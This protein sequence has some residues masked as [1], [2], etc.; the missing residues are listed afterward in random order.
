MTA[1]R[2]DPAGVNA[3]HPIADVVAR[4]GVALRPAGRSHVGR[5]PFHRDRGRPNFYVYPATGRFVC[6][7]C[8]AH[9][10]A[11]DF[12]AAREGCRFR[13]AVAL[14][15]GEATP[16]RVAAPPPS[17]PPDPHRRDVLNLATT[18]YAARFRREPVA[19]HYVASRG[20]SPAVAADLRVGYACGE[21]LPALRAS[22]LPLA[23]AERAGLLYRRRDGS[24]VELLAGRVTVPEIRRG[25]TVWMTGRACPDRHGRP[26]RGPR[27]LALPLKRLLGVERAA[28]ADEVIVVE[29]PFDWLALTAWGYPALALGGTHP[30][31]A[32]RSALLAFLARRERVFLALDQDGA[33]REATAA[34]L[35][36]LG[37]RAVDVPLPGVKDVA[38]LATSP[39]GRAAFRDALHLARSH[40]PAPTGVGAG[41]S[42]HTPQ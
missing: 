10:D 7:R 20:L 34:L 14:L 39:D 12:V 31:G 36:A 37:P 11:I 5:C 13:D 21:L 41:A 9:G 23:A 15:D 2:I 27:Y 26:P 33:G 3:R 29:G 38:E 4:Y 16:M 24:L 8:G 18:I 19:R 40:A 17:P 35:A 32:A 28:R 25:Q 30:P 22:G 6:Y 1:V 42:W